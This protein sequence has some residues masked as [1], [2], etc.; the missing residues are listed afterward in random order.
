MTPEER[1]EY[2][3][4]YSLNYYHEKIKPFPEK[5]KKVRAIR[6]EQYAKHK[7]KS[8]AYK[9]QYYKKNVDSE[10]IYAR[11]YYYANREKILMKAKERY[12]IAKKV[13]LR[14]KNKIRDRTLKEALEFFDPALRRAAELAFASYLADM[15]ELKSKKMKAYNKKYY[16]QN[17]K[18]IS[19]DKEVAKNSN[20][21]TYTDD[22]IIEVIE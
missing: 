17:A 3:R 7:E 11:E 22:V 16:E 19:Y 20:H 9:K 12:S 1:K 4:E 5:M 18:K 6:R 13:V 21:P 10:R 15:R 2:A 8:K 14:M